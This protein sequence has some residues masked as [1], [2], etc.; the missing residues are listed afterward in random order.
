MM[1]RLKFKLSL[2][3]NILLIV[4]INFEFTNSFNLPRET[5]EDNAYNDE[6]NA[7]EYLKRLNQET[8]IALLN[9]SQAQ[10]E[11]ATNI[12]EET[13]NKAVR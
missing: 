2:I 3:L 9:L 4:L 7:T 13:Q 12:N 1:K 8:T 6:T 5:F 10:W 11:F